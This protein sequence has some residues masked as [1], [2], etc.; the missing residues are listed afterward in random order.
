M[1]FD[2]AI[3]R[4]Y[5]SFCESN[6][7]LC[8]DSRN[9]T[10]GD[11]FICLKGEKFDG[12][13]FAIQALEKGASTVV[14]DAIELKHDQRF[15]WVEDTTAALQSLG[16]RHAE[17]MPAKKI[18]IGGSN[19]KT[20]T[21]EV[22]RT[23]LEGIGNTLATPGN[24]NNHIG[25]PL[26]LLSLR[27]Q[28]QFAI[29]ELGTNHPGE[30]KVLCDLIRPDLGLITN[31]GKEHLEGFGNIENVAKEESEVYLN[32]IK[33]KQKGIVNI[34]D[35]WLESMCKRLHLKTTI[36]TS[37]SNSN[38]YLEIHH[39]MPK[40]TFTLYHNLKTIG[41]F[42]SQLSGRYNA[43]NLLF[44]CAIG[45]ENGLTAKNAMSLA[46]NYVPT[47][48]RSEWK[49]FGK[50]QIFLDA[51]NANPSSMEFAIDSFAT[52]KGNKTLFLGDMLEL[53]EHSKFE[54]TQLLSKIEKM[55]LSSSTYLV[56][57][58]FYAAC[59]AHPFV[60]ENVD[61]MLAWLDTHPIEAEFVF[62]KGSRGIKMERVLEHF[63]K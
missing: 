29:I 45:V 44:A 47:N 22:T 1:E 7:Q 56:G 18:I 28:H 25:V 14:V 4:I 38:F 9:I 54:H 41:D 62:I 5:Q 49:N 31:I 46:C 58:E 6:F 8:T 17:N 10:H 57:Q 55:G 21:K 36:S 2:E 11:I 26:T 19:G 61:S 53:G 3:I 20:T 52:L 30:M 51:Y 12:N 42:E 27:P 23:V 33:H 50:T 60:F 48:N 15:I 24:W 59:S 43:Y 32:L 13:Q 40:L 16:K 39:E 34:D 37:S 63:V 35:P